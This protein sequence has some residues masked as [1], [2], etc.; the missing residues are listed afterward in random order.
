MDLKD[1]KDDL[2]WLP[3][4]RKKRILKINFKKKKFKKEKKN[5]GKENCQILCYHVTKVKIEKLELILSLATS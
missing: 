4:K 1:S 2:R 5:R 3:L